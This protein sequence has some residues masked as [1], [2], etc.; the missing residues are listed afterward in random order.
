MILQV[1]RRRSYSCAGGQ[2]EESHDLVLRIPGQRVTGLDELSHPLVQLYDA[3]LQL[4][5]GQAQPDGG[6]A[7][8]LGEG[9]VDHD[10]MPTDAFVFVELRRLPLGI[11]AENTCTKRQSGVCADNKGCR[12]T[13]GKATASSQSV[14]VATTLPALS[15][16][17]HKAP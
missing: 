1:I 15:E 10:G 16:K 12:E 6:A 17:K 8:G 9:D 11:L 4:L 5:I 3:H 2:T 14:S 13:M 7:K